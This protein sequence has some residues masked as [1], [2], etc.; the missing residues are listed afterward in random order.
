[1]NYDKNLNRKGS[2]HN[3]IE[4]QRNVIFNIH[5]L[6]DSE[7]VILHIKI[8][9][10][11]IFMPLSPHMQCRSPHEGHEYFWHHGR[12]TADVATLSSEQMLEQ[13]V[14]TEQ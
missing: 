11:N 5:I 1:M 8:K 14:L 9:V 6:L 4:R 12:H 13:K 2:I 7:K 3:D 10:I